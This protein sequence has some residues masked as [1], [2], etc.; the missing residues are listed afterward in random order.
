MARTEASLAHASAA[1]DLTGDAVLELDS[2]GCITAANPGALRLFGLSDAA[3]RGVPG[4]DLVAETDQGVWERCLALAL[5]GER[6]ERIPVAVRRGRG[7]VP[8]QASLAPVHDEA[9]GVLALCVVLRDVEEQHVTQSTLAESALRVAESEALAHVGSWAWDASTDAVQWSEELHR[10]HGIRVGDFNGTLVAQVER[11]HPDDRPEI[12]RALNLSRLVGAPFDQEFR[13]LWPD[14]TMRWVHARATPVLGPGGEGIGLRGIYHDIT[15]RHESSAVLQQANEQLRQYALYDGLTGLPNRLLLLERLGTVLSLARQSGHRVDVLY[16]DIDDF[17]TINDSRGHQAGDEVLTAVATLLK[18]SVRAQESV[19][20][21][22]PGCVGRLGSDE[23]VLVLDDCPDPDAVV[24]RIQGQLKSPLPLTGTE[25]FVSVSIGIATTLSPSAEDSPERLLT[26]A[27]V[28]MHEAKRAGKGQHL[29]FQPHM[30]EAART[31]HELGNQL[32]RAIDRG[33]FELA[34]QPVV[35]L[36]GARILGAEALVRW[37]HPERGVLAPGEFITRAEETGLIVPLGAW[38]L[39]E[40]CRQA[41]AWAADGQ[42]E[43]TIAVNVSGRQLREDFFLASVRDAL[44]SS[45]LEPHRLCLEMT[46]SMLMERDDEAITLLTQLR[47]EGI[48]LA[49]DDFGTGYSSL[50]ALRRLPVDLLKIDRSFVASLPDDD[51]AATIAWA[52]IRLGHTL[53]M[54]VLAE[55]I[56][57][58]EQQEALRGFGCDQAQGYLFGRPMPAGD[59][60]QRLAAQRG[61]PA[62]QALPRG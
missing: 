31:R 35:T 1:I 25:V 15:E 56:E 12:S 52:I 29:A 46:E 10:I 36:E 60:G 37:R 44:E 40:A 51:D 30:Y 38:V 58:P 3:L 41:K 48:H 62:V 28:A 39:N 59:F 20:L 11:V 18:Q 21:S 22:A 57:T 13:V 14:G 9:G 61:D 4:A 26:A 50:G 27:N 49:I 6:Q 32:H 8:T 16:L 2:S 7:L 54:S 42:V 55:G 24:G 34:Y 17:K 53:G 23:F 43:F 5:T 33:E 47:E 45:G 19:D